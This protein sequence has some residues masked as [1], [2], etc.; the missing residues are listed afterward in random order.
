MNLKTKTEPVD[1]KAVDAAGITWAVRVAPAPHIEIV[2][3]AHRLGIS[4]ADVRG[5]DEASTLV[6]QA[7]A[8]KHLVAIVSATSK[9]GEAVSF[10]GKDPNESRAALMEHHTGLARAVATIAVTAGRTVEEQRGNL[11]PGSG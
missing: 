9:D 1:G 7:I 8:A 4:L 10:N 3:T 6:E 2:R 5:N 11:P